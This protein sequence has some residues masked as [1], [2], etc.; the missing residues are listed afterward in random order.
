MAEY[1]GINE[2]VFKVWKDQDISSLVFDPTL[3]FKHS[4]LSE[5]V[6]KNTSMFEVPL[7]HES[8]EIMPFKVWKDMDNVSLTFNL[9][10]I[11]T[12]IAEDVIEWY[13]VRETE[14]QTEAGAII[15]PPNIIVQ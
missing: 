10:Y 13:G 4:G 2:S 5:A 7:I 14:Q 3:L 8:V 11:T 12:S 1:D 6:F 15:L 9:A